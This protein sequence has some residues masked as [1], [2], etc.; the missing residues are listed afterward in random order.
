M[1]ILPRRSACKVGRLHSG[2]CGAGIQACVGKGEV[3]C[4]SLSIWVVSDSSQSHKEPQNM[5]FHRRKKWS[6]SEDKVNKNLCGMV[7]DIYGCHI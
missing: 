2:I 3:Y 4:I 7:R 1:E 5:F 6:S